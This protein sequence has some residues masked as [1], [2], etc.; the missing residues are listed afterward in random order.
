MSIIA[1]LSNLMN[2]LNPILQVK[3]VFVKYT[4]AVYYYIQD[5]IQTISFCGYTHFLCSPF[6]TL[7][8][9]YVLWS[10]YH[11]QYF[12]HTVVGQFWLSVFHNC[13]IKPQETYCCKKYPLE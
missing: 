2:F 3:F 13:H 1:N 6:L 9:L 12:M 4:F 8:V 5:N 10:H 11:R 7:T